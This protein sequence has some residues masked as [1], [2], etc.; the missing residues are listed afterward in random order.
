MQKN[1]N[2]PEYLLYQN[3]RFQEG[4]SVKDIVNPFNGGLV[5]KVHFADKSMMKAA[6]DY[7]VIGFEKMSSLPLYKRVEILEGIAAGIDKHFIDISLTLAQEAAKPIKLA[8]GEVSR[9]KLTFKTAAEEAKRINGEI[10]PLDWDESAQNR[11]GFVQRFPLGVIFGIT[12]FNFPLNLAAHKAAPAL[13]AGNSIIIKP[14]SSDPI[15]ALWLARLAHEAG[16]PAGALQ[17]LPAAAQ[18]TL[19]IIEDEQVKML[20]FTG[21]A[22][23]GWKLKAQSGKKKI[24]LELGGNAGVIIDKDTDLDYACSRC[25]MGG[26]AYAGQV[27]ISVQRIIIH[28][29]IYEQFTEMLVQGVKEKVKTGNPLDEEVLLSSMI[30]EKEAVRVESWIQE[31]CQNGAK[32]LVGGERK[33]SI[34]TPAVLSNVPKDAK[35]YQDEVFGPVVT[36]EKFETFD[37]ALEIINDT[38]FGLQAGVFTNRMDYGMKAFKE[39]EAGGVMI[40]DVPTFRIDPMPYGGIKDSGLGREGLRYAIEEMTEPK[41]MVINNR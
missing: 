15:S 7:A 41:L 22:E 25:L 14:S 37:Q 18:D 16:A 6:I 36:V 32:L 17:V 12:P 39:I 28:K 24:A 2:P 20:T 33:G 10:L 29:D 4:A 23:T 26:F 40:N 38:R 21:S 11:T 9:C 5:G 30:N 27:C 8:K 3:G 31:A 13:A 1:T 34:I 35:V 19:P